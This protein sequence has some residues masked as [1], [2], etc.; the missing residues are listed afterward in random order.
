[1]KGSWTFA[2]RHN[3]VRAKAVAHDSDAGG[4][5]FATVCANLRQRVRPVNT[6]CGHL[7]A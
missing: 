1:M 3:L 2:L 4:W 6:R 7:T 5:K